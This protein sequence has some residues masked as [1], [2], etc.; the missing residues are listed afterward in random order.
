MRKLD[1]DIYDVERQYAPTNDILS[2]DTKETRRLKMVI[3]DLDETDRR[4]ILAYA[5]LASIR[6]CARL[7]NV[8][9]T[10][11]WK[12]IKEIKEQIKSKLND[13]N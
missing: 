5:E 11:I 4:I 8:S 3:N 2:E 6:D 10:T 12:K 13:Y 7:F 9:A 1:F